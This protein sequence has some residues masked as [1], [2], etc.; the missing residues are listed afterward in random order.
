MIESDLLI[1]NLPYF[2]SYS[3]I[4]F[5]AETVYCSAYTRKLMKRGF[6][7][8]P[9]LPIYGLGGI[10]IKEFLTC[11]ADR[12][13]L[14]FCCSMII[15]SALEYVSAWL[16]EKL[17]ALK[18]WDYSKAFLNIKGRVCLKNSLFFGLSGLALIFW[19]NPIIES[20]I[21]LLP[22][23]ILIFFI[24]LCSVLFLVDMV[25]SILKHWK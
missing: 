24:I 1:E 17:F 2:F 10:I 13:F 21:T 6:L 15:T 3:I 14:I 5:A 12:P 16:L 25:A 22:K 11:L 9:W 23:K 8:G 20:G 18:L 19:V 7:H 4:G